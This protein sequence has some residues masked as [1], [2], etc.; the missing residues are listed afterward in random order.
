MNGRGAYFSEGGRYRYRLWRR[1]DLGSM[2]V[3]L[4]LN[5]S[6]AGADKD[7]A[8]IRRCVGFAKMWGYAGIE[9]VNLYPLVE[10]DAK[11]AMRSPDRTDGGTRNYHYIRGA[12]WQHQNVVCAWGATVEPDHATN[13]LV[14]DLEKIAG[15]ENVRCLGVTKSGQPR[16]PVRLPYATELV[17]L[18]IAQGRRAT[19]GG[20]QASGGGR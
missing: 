17:P 7:D 4:M 10:T 20:V 5:P 9:V 1:W 18:S 14:G 6:K 3:W 8:T 12:V 16:H 15:W 11:L 2:C 19:H 13:C